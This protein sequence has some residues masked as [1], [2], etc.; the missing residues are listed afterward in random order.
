MSVKKVGLEAFKARLNGMSD[1]DLQ[2]LLGQYQTRLSLIE[3]AMKDPF[4][5]MKFTT[6]MPVAKV[7]V[8][9]DA[10]TR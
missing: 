8:K 5:I 1:E 6:Q 4:S 9:R 3:K 2:K 10:G 7:S